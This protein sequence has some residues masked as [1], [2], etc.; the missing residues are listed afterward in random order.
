MVGVGGQVS[1]LQTDV[2]RIRLKLSHLFKTS[3]QVVLHFIGISSNVP[4]TIEDFS[5]QLSFLQLGI[6]DEISLHRKLGSSDFTLAC[7]LDFPKSA[8]WD[9]LSTYFPSPTEVINLVRRF[10]SSIMCRSDV[11]HV[12]LGSA[13]NLEQFSSPMVN[14]KLLRLLMLAHDGANIF[15]WRIQ[16]S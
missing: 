13:I 3:F 12:F 4:P 8:E 7:L 10:S 11:E 16:G 5:Y 9:V 15:F 2:A 6:A 14:M 1:L